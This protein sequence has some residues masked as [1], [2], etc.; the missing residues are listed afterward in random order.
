MVL[1]KCMNKDCNNYKQE[2]ENNPEVC[3][4][5]G[6]KTEAVQTNVNT[7]L[8]SIVAIIAVAFIVAPFLL[9]DTIGMIGLWGGFGVGIVCVGVACFTRS[10]PAIVITILSLAASIGLLFYF[11]GF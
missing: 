11:I 3:P 7:K 8:A 5:C 2:L 10:I 6:V 4:L 9:V 1:I